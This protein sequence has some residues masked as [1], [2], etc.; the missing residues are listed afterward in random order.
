MTSCG[1]RGPPGAPRN[2]ASPVTR[3]LPAPS[4]WDYH[5]APARRLN[6]WRTHFDDFQQQR[7]ESRGDRVHPPHSHPTRGCRFG[8][9]APPFGNDAPAFSIEPP[10][11]AHAPPAFE[12]MPRFGGEPLA[13]PKLNLATSSRPTPRLSRTQPSPKLA[14]DS[15]GRSVPFGTA[16]LFGTTTAAARLFFA[17][18][19]SPVNRPGTT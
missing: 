14:G 15:A 18:A 5:D 13:F 19:S 11:S 3:R 2:R 12:W 10:P 9:D 16:E 17:E 4:P 7:R 1:T 6:A 8:S